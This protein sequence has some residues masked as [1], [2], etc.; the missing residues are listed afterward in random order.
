MI[1]N[2]HRWAF[3]ICLQV[4]YF[5]H[6]L[7]ESVLELVFLGMVDF[8]EVF[9]CHFH[10]VLEYSAGDVSARYG[11][12]KIVNLFSRWMTPED[13]VHIVPNEKQYNGRDLF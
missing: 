9:I 11:F 3:I 7:S 4:F 10:E 1:G 13:I 2:D 12:W 6:K 8:D 5:L